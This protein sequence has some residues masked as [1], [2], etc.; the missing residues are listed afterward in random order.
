M[1]EESYIKL[2]EYDPD[3]TVYPWPR[4]RLTMAS[5]YSVF[6]KSWTIGDLLDERLHGALI[7]REF[8][9]EQTWAETARRNM[10]LPNEA[11]VEIDLDGE[12]VEAHVIVPRYL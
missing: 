6:E 2:I 1:A 5:H 4:R 11:E 7:L 3:V 8:I 9:K 10:D 12:M